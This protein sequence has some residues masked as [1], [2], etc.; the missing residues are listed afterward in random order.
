MKCMTATLS[1]LAGVLLLSAHFASAGAGLIPG[2]ETVAKEFSDSPPSLVQFSNDSP[3]FRYLLTNKNTEAFTEMVAQ[4][5]PLGIRLAGFEGLMA[6]DPGEGGR[7][8][9]ENCSQ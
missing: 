5:K 9:L 6:L 3:H 8:R 1:V 7:V 4:G 2:W